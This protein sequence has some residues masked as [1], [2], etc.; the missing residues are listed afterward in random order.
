[1][2][3]RTSSP[4]FV[5]RDADLDVLAEAFEASA[6]GAP[7]FVVV[8]G[9]AG[10]GKSRLVREATQDAARGGALVLLGECLDIG[11]AG[12]PYL[13]L[14]GALRGLARQV[15]AERLER[16]VGPGGAS[17]RRSS[18][19]SRPTRTPPRWTSSD[20]RRDSAR[21]GS[22]SASWGCSGRSPRTAPSSSSSRTSTGSTARPATC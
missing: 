3:A 16:A 14:A 9:E 7:R 6:S 8:R 18:P 11:P 1:M 17:S 5:G 19:S 12:L 13:P 22:S 21:R 4:A 15:D 20:C 2:P 10:I